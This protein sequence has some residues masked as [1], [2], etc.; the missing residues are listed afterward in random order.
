MPESSN[1]IIISPTE[2]KT[3]F[4]CWSEAIRR[5][6]DLKGRTT[7]YEFWAFQTVSLSIF[8]L[9]ALF[10]F[11]LGSYK[12]IFEIYLLYF[13]A[14]ATTVS[15]RRLHDIG[16]SGWWT[17]PAL[18]FAIIMLVCWEIN[19]DFVILSV[20]LLL[21]YMSYLYYILSEQGYPQDNEYGIR[22]FE[23]EIYNQDSKVFII[24]MATFLGVLW[25][26][27]LARILL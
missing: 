12:I 2:T 7:R 20:F 24:F 21:S 15:V 1:D 16:L 8:I 14:P 5:F 4:N 19:T 3:I 6:F 9:A 22:V 26:F 11:I 23:P 10:G 25:V 17:I 27:F 13:L 18:I